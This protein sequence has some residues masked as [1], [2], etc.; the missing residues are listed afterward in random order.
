MRIL[1]P[2]DGSALSMR[3][4]EHVARFV[5]EGEVV[6]LHVA[7]IPPEL[8]E[9]RGAQRSEEER[10]LEHEVGEGARRFREEIRPRIESEVFGP[11]KE[12]LSRG[13]REGELRVR[14]L[15]ATDPSPDPTPTIL[16]EAE[17]ERY[18]A[19][20]IGRRAHSGIM[21]FRLGGTASKVVHHLHDTPIWLVP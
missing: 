12:R 1:V 19:V 17:R 18:D 3:A 21:S 5:R 16:A 13:A 8:I 14:T 7:G 15:L 9:H 2:I 20:V 11:A 6:L 10:A 4:V